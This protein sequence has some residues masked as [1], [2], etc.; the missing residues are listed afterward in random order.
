M[1]FPD[2]INI[3]TD[4]WLK[5]ISFLK[6]I[7]LLRADHALQNGFEDSPSSRVDQAAWSELRD[8]D[9][10]VLAL[11]FFGLSNDE[12]AAKLSLKNSRVVT[13]SVIR[14]SNALGI[15]KD[16]RDE[17]R[18]SLQ[19]LSNPK[20]IR[21]YKDALD[22]DRL[23]DFFYNKKTLVETDSPVISYPPAYIAGLI[24]GFIKNLDKA[25]Q[26]IFK[27]EFEKGLKHNEIAPKVKLHKSRVF[28]R[29]REYKEKIKG[30]VA[31]YLSFKAW[32]PRQ[33]D[34]SKA[35]LL[36]KDDISILRSFLKNDDFNLIAQ[37]R[38]ITERTVHNRLAFIAKSLGLNREGLY[39]I[40][41]HHLN[42]RDFD[43]LYR[44]LLQ[45]LFS[46]GGAI[47]DDFK[48][49]A[50]FYDK[51]SLFKALVTEIKNFNPRTNKR[52]FKLMLQGYSQGAISRKLDVS[53]SSVSVS[54]S[55]IRKRLLDFLEDKLK[56]LTQKA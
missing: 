6:Q 7:A 14:A 5:G 41:E 45:F 22:R 24:Q 9:K 32:L 29:S 27:L 56:K 3:E 43:Y 50:K 1:K 4:S 47:P 20:Q 53:Q 23:I 54:L 36:T 10:Q 37:D 40:K 42:K 15:N 8:C 2:A 51:R 26:K 13:S 21:G 34:P 25:D 18:D 52:Y 38:S 19:K 48:E 49:L 28:S 55:R 30:W 33:I 12:I 44:N 39:E 46:P 16:K 35:A 11:S 31:N 17:I